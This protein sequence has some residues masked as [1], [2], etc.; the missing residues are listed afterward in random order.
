MTIYYISE[1]IKEM[2][3]IIKDA[4][5]RNGRG[6][7]IVLDGIDGAGK[8][9]IAHELVQQLNG[10]GIET[11]YTKEPGGIEQT[12]ALETFIRNNEMTQFD[13]TLLFLVSMSLNLNK[14]ILPALDA[15][16]CVVCD[17]FLRSTVVYQGFC[18]YNLY[19]PEVTDDTVKTFIQAVK[20]MTHDGQYSPDIEILIDIDPNVA[21][22]N[23][24][25]RGKDLDKFESIGLDK[26]HTKMLASQYLI[27]D[28]LS[29]YLSKYYTPIFNDPHKNSIEMMAGMII[30][31]IES[32]LVVL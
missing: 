20:T 28:E 26:L 18:L 8:T 5:E 30:K 17:R 27:N 12:K 6:L 11:L 32:R 21:L 7:F 9:S 10:S 19:Y 4:I 31:T 22:Q 14:N 15:K 29:G 16:K 1:V 25:S 13:Y 24:L 2:S 3:K 23:L